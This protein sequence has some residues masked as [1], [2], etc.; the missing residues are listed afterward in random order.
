MNIMPHDNFA[1]PKHNDT[2][3]DFSAQ[4]SA[5]CLPLCKLANQALTGG[6]YHVKPT[7]W[8]F[9]TYNHVTEQQ[10]ALKKRSHLTVISS[11]LLSV[12]LSYH[13]NPLMRQQE[14]TNDHCQIQ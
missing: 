13:H 2:S 8:P 9:K 6:P 14:V 12:H 3:G 5:Y 1:Q 4:Q 7:L 11:H 10:D